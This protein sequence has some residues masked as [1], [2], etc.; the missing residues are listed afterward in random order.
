MAVEAPVEIRV[1][2]RVELRYDPEDLT[3][4][5]VYVDGTAAGVARPF[6]LG[7]RLSYPDLSLFQVVEGLRYAFPRMMKRL[8]KT[9]PRVVEVKT[10]PAAA[11]APSDAVAASVPLAAPVAV[12][13]AEAADDGQGWMATLLGVLLMAVASVAQST[14]VSISIYYVVASA[15]A[16]SNLAR[17]DGVRYGHRSEKADNLTDLYFDSRG[18]GFENKLAELANEAA[19][20]AG[21]PEAAEDQK[22][23]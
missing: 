16:S 11:P 19:E 1:G 14:A 5:D 2:R 23:K 4:I 17:F 18:E 7:R 22:D 6:L 12:T 20:A 10:L 9:V 13:V 15:E 3:R 8:E 21:D